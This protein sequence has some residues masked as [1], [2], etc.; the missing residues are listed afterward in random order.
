MDKKD[1]LIMSY[2]R[3]N[4]RETLTKISRST[5]LPVST[6]YERLKRNEVNLSLHHCSLVDFA[7]LGYRA[8]A[9]VLLKAPNTTRSKLRTYLEKHQHVNSLVKINNGYD[10][11]AEIIFKQV[12]D[13]EG[14]M[15]LLE[16][17]FRVRRQI[18]YVLSDIT[19]ERFLSDPALLDL[20][21]I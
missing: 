6:V 16:D 10:F 9:Q 17:K 7:K 19:K 13:L 3:M 2:L 8:K 21:A 5:K 20:V 12:S 4:A 1:L 18:H 11:M 14:F 15:E